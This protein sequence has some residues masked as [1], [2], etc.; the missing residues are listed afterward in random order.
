[1]AFSIT[2]PLAQRNFTDSTSAYA[3]SRKS[4]IINRT[5]ITLTGVGNPFTPKQLS[6]LQEIEGLLNS[7]LYQA[8]GADLLRSIDR[9]TY[10]E[11]TN[12]SKSFNKALK[13]T[14]PGFYVVNRSVAVGGNANFS[15]FSS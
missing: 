2:V 6:R 12:L 11:Y 14:K 3:A 13:T 15:I 8:G 1:M 5:L 7:P 4:R 9:K 10:N